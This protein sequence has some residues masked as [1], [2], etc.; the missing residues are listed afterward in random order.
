MAAFATI[1][2]GTKYLSR[3]IVNEVVLAYSERRQCLGDSAVAGA[4]VGFN[5]QTLSFWRGMQD[6][7]ETNCVKWV[8]DTNFST[9]TEYDHPKDIAYTLAT[10]R[11][12]AGLNASGFRRATAWPGTFG[13]G[14]MQEGDIIGPWIV[15]DLQKAFDA[16]RWSFTAAEPFILDYVIPIYF[17]ENST[18]PALITVSLPTYFER[19]VS[20]EGSTEANSYSDASDNWPTGSGVGAVLPYEIWCATLFS[21]GQWTCFV[22]RSNAEVVFS[23][24]PDHLSH[25]ADM[26]I[27]FNDNDYSCDLSSDPDSLGLE[28]R[29]M[30]LLVSAASSTTN[31]RTMPKATNTETVPPFGDYEINGTASKVA[32]VLKWDFTNTL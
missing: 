2:T 9:L 13:Y 5:L 14:K 8:D 3:D 25:A 12:E 10:F 24:I 1:T 6:W 31:T 30:T 28:L 32:I 26:Y 21:G 29:K 7:I 11:T 15:E 23:E 16:M 27:H 20:G 18:T 4:A 19:T 17:P 22:R